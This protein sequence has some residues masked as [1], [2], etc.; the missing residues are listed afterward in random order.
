ME[1]APASTAKVSVERLVRKLR[2]K[3]DW[4]SKAETIEE[5][6]S[7][8]FETLFGKDERPF[9]LYQISRQ[10]QLRRVALAMNARRQGNKLGDEA[11]FVEFSLEWFSSANL[12]VTNTAGE[13]DCHWVNAMHVD[14]NGE[15]DQFHLLL[16]AALR[17][18]RRMIHLDKKSM[19]VF[20]EQA[21][22]EQCQ[23]VPG[24]QQPCR[25]PECPMPVLRDT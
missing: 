19:K 9:S 25:V 1:L 21:Q 6:A 11:F 15:Q 24:Q 3:A 2:R 22:A 4:E 10:D 7:D 8:L 5:R 14:V 17:A 16:Q 12:M 13:T 23:A 20:A 18:E